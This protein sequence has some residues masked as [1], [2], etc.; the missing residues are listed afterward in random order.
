[1]N[2][3]LKYTHY[4]KTKTFKTYK[5]IF[6]RWVIHPMNEKDTK[7]PVY[8]AI[9]IALILV[10]AVV[11]LGGQR[12]ETPG[13]EGMTPVETTTATPS[14]TAKPGET[15]TATTPVTA[16]PLGSAATIKCE[17][18]HKESQN[19]VPHMN[20]GKLCVNC[21][22]SQVHNIHVGTGTIDLK[23]DICHG[24]P[25]KI[26]I[27]IVEKGEGPGHYSTC[28]QCHAAPPDD[29]KPSNGELVMI[30]LSRGIYCTNCHGTDVGIIHEKSLGN[31]I[32]K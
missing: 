18:C 4:D 28:E 15:I 30:H 14:E 11:I 29:L 1:M 23:C 10:A 13:E 22:G 20:G 16:A 21:H 32:N 19:L 24:P 8:L 3:G 17:L 9:I 5:A 25:E 6:N 31:T 26:T 2:A 7:V 27:P 12:G